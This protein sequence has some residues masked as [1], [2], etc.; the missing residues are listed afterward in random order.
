MLTINSAGP[1]TAVYQYSRHCH[2]ASP[3]SRLFNLNLSGAGEPWPEGTEARGFHLGLYSLDVGLNSTLPR[4]AF[5]S[6]RE[7]VSQAQTNEEPVHYT[8]LGVPPFGARDL[9]VVTIHDSPATALRSG[10][11]ADRTRYR[12]L[13]RR[14]LRRYRRY[15]RILTG[16]EYVRRAVESFGVDG[17]VTVIPH[18]VSPM[19]KPLRDEKA[20][21]RRGLELPVD[22]HLVL[23]VSSAEPRKN[24]R[25]MPR[26]MELLG[27][28]YQLIRV[29]PATPGSIAY[30]DISEE[31][32]N[33]LY[34]ASDVFLFPSFEEG[35]GL[36]VAEAMTCGLPVVASDI[37]V[38][39][40]VTGGAAILADPSSPEQLAAAVREALSDTEHLRTL[41]FERAKRYSFSRFK[42]ELGEYMQA[43][44]WKRAL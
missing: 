28:D 17:H 16:T 11:Y 30:S 18:P 35:L 3:E 36:P 33:T 19:L 13:Q 4:R 7:A 40:E 42:E 38:M 15:P 39:H 25:V 10:L 34:G 41:G 20:T 44:G 22:R 26:V 1:R 14:R 43:I 6:V 32:L 12:L 24:L 23:S 31:A 5:R 29:G 9:S 37:E 27:S 2:Q 21:L 8:S